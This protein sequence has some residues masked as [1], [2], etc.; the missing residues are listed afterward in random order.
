MAITIASQEDELIE[1]LLA[2]TNEKSAKTEEVNLVV[3]NICCVSSGHRWIIY[4]NG[5]SNQ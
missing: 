5:K 4:G 1:T 3:K 2:K